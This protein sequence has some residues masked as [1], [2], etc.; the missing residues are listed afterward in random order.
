VA[1][2]GPPR[3][4]QAWC[5]HHRPFPDSTH[6]KDDEQ[7]RTID[8]TEHALKHCIFVTRSQTIRQ[9]SYNPPNTRTP[10]AVY[11]ARTAPYPTHQTVSHTMANPLD[12]DAG[13][14]LF[15]NYEAELKLVQ[16]DLNQKLDQLPE[17]AGE[18]RKAAIS[19]AQRSLEEATEIVS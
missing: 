15:S 1:A 16:A 4:V 8:Q 2:L 13:S 19:R 6:M 12:T 18:E 10:N 11:I 17:L 5:Q 14:E 3:V 9:L 7:S